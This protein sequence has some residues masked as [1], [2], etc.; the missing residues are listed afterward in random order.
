MGI[1]A[2]PRFQGSNNTTLEHPFFRQT[3][4]EDTLSE[5]PTAAGEVGLQE[6]LRDLL[7][8]ERVGFEPTEGFPSNDFE[9]FAF[10]HSATSPKTRWACDT[11]RIG[12][13]RAACRYPLGPLAAQAAG[14]PAGMAPLSQSRL[15]PSSLRWRRSRAE[16]VKPSQTPS[17]RPR[18]TLG[19]R[20]AQSAW[21]SGNSSQR[22]RP[23]CSWMARLSIATGAAL[24][25]GLASL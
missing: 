22:Q 5:S 2:V 24:S 12:Q 20:Q 16:G 7:N 19:C 9:S 11:L 15:A 13:P 21:R 18:C 8:T 25:P 1:A 14:K 10:D 4:L 3:N 23:S 17:S 6:S